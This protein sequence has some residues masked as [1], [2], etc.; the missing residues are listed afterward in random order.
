LL[1]VD[2]VETYYLHAPDSATP[3]EETLSA[4]NDL[5]KQGKFKNF[6]LSNFS[7]EQVQQIYDIASKNNYVL[8]T[9]YQ[10]N[11]NPVARHIETDLFPVLRKLNIRFYVYSPV[12]GGFLSKTVDQIKQGGQG[13]WDPNSFMGQLY[14]GLYNRPKVLEGLEEWG[15]IANES[16]IS[17]TELAY[18][19]VAFHSAVKAENG[20]A[21][22]V[23]ASRLE[24]LEQTVEGLR[25]GPL[26]KEVVE[27]IEG[28]WEL[29]KN[30][31]PI[32]NFEG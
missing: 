18:R 21:I 11:Y 12:A 25:R 27:R 6:G 28:V 4:I 7:P 16:G 3:I 15:R 17:R 10:G 13:R 31:A 29:V 24:Q 1:K 20:D 9:V 19:F 26:P 30:D 5:H 22:I 32:N 23:G 14:H 2:S 8:P